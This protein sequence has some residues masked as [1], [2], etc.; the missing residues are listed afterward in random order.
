MAP[1]APVMV[2]SMS[3]SGRRQTGLMDS[4]V[5]FDRY[6]HEVKGET[7]P[8]DWRIV[9]LLN[10]TTKRALIGMT[11]LDLPHDL[12]GEGPRSQRRR[13]SRRPAYGWRD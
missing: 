4:P 6:I 10:E 9:L 1:I 2:R 13:T 5:L 7:A 8:R 11:R 12:T 3:I